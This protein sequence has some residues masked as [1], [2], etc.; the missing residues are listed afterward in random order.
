MVRE[1]QTASRKLCHRQLSWFRDERLFRWLEGDRPVGTIVDEIL[2]GYHSAV[3]P[4]ASPDCCDMI[5]TEFQAKSSSCTLLRFFTAAES[6]SF[7]S[8]GA[9]GSSAV[10]VSAGLSLVWCQRFG[11][12]IL[13][14]CWGVSD[15]SRCAGSLDDQGKLT[16]EQE[17]ELRM[18]ITHFHRIANTKTQQQILQ[19]ISSMVTPPSGLAE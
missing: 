17:K 3:N 10:S 2:A 6:G 5:S 1:V 16:K 19:E 14:V 7:K 4:G 18:Y 9:S 12:P 15:A 8:A 11:K 13:L